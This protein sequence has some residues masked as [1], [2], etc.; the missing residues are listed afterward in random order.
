MKGVSSA[1]AWALAGPL[2]RAVPLLVGLALAPG[3]AHLAGSAATG[4]SAALSQA[5]SL[6]VELYFGRRS[7]G[8]WITDDE[9]N[10]FEKTVVRPLLPGGYTIMQARGYWT[11]TT[12]E[13]VSEETTILMVAFPRETP[14][15]TIDARVDPIRRTYCAQFAQES[16]LR[17]DTATQLSFVLPPSPPPQ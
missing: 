12:G 10:A 2:L 15:A 14:S 6:K 16:V 8:R 3:C 4:P 9:F 1:R 7:E 5:N 13:S 17:L 11:G